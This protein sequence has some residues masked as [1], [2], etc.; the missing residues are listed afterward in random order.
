MSKSD[1]YNSG[2]INSPISYRLKHVTI[3]N[4]QR[5]QTS[6]IIEPKK[7]TKLK[8]KTRQYQMLTK[9]AK[10]T[11]PCEKIATSRYNVRIQHPFWYIYRQQLAVLLIG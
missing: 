3:P 5:S 9:E 4:G 10:H 11:L 6:L 2:R 1:Q 8:F 7:C